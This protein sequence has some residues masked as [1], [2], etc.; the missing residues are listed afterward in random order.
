MNKKSIFLIFTSSLITLLL[1]FVVKRNIDY[2][3]YYEYPYSLKLNYSPIFSGTGKSNWDIS[4]KINLNIDV[5]QY[6]VRKKILKELDIQTFNVNHVKYKVIHNEIINKKIERSLIVFTAFDGMEIPAY[7][8]KP[9][10]PKLTPIILVLPGHVKDGES[11]IEQ[12]SRE[13]ESY[14]HANANQLALHGYTTLTFELRGFGYLGKPKF[15]DHKVVAYNSLLANTT[16]KAIIFKDISYAKKILLNQNNIDKNRLGI[17]GVSFGG[18]LSL[19]YAALD[20]DINV[21]VSQSYGGKTGYKKYLV[22]PLSDQ[23]HYCHFLPDIDLNMRWEDWFWLIAPRPLLISR[24]N[25]EKKPSEQSLSRYQLA[26]E[27]FG[28]REKFIFVLG[29]GGHEY[30]IEPSLEHFNMFF[31]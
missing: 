29:H 28:V 7:I 3:D 30:F 1:L 31:N 27:N 5:W 13:I 6:E 16:Y 21:V 24:G 22:D 23:P 17:T 8:H 4:Q 2:F 12:T 15:P 20:E 14:Q 26:W 10:T 9:I 25:D 18:E 11:G 19:Q